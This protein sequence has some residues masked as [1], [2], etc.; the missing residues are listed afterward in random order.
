[1]T[2]R[3]E[4]KTT[5]ETTEEPVI[6]S[7]PSVFTLPSGLEVFR[8]LPEDGPGLE[9]LIEG[10][11]DYSE[12]SFGR[13]PG[14]AS[15]SSQLARSRDIVPT[16]RTLPLGVRVE[17]E[18]ILGA[19]A[20]LGYPDAETL[21]VDLL[22]IGPRYRGTGVGGE[23]VRALAEWAYEKAARRMRVDCHFTGDEEANAFW[24]RLGFTE[25]ARFAESQT[26]A[27]PRAR[28]LLSGPL[29]LR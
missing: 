7:T 11:G 1:M 21:V 24:S 2:T 13:A 25:F 4:M 18:L 3:G 6:A 15:A 29:P 17:D 26:P 22:L 10:C 14:H 8:L 12:I 20:V 27:G 23:F 19:N 9:R 5:G 16:E 28:V